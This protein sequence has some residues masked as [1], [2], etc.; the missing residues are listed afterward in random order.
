MNVRLYSMP[1]SGNS[2][3]IRLLLALTGRRVEVIDCEYGSAALAEAKLAGALPYGKV[4]VLSLRDGTQL[5]ES[6]AILW[7][8]GEGS[9]FMPDSPVV[10]AQMLGWMFWEQYNHEPVIAVRQA[11]LNY[12]HR[13]ADATPARL[14]ELLDRGH[15]VLEVMERQLAVSDWLAG[16]DVSLADICLYAYTHTAGT[17]GGYAMDRFPGISAWA[18][19]MTS[20]PGYKGL[21][22]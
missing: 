1:S 17:R 20:M 8:L 10:R 5:A 21:H 7:Y 13:A 6:N 4:P 16:G 11:L 18:D 2:Y 12:P 22:G 19:R 9:N 3:K 14:A 15:V